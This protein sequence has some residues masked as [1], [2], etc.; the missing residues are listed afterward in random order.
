MSLSK[1]REITNALEELQKK[2]PQGEAVEQL[3]AMSFEERSWIM[4]KDRALELCKAFS[5]KHDLAELSDGKFR[6][7]A[8]DNELPRK[9]AELGRN[10]AIQ[11]ELCGST[12]SQNRE[13]FADGQHQ[14]FVFR[15]FNIDEQMALYPK[16]TE[17]L[18]EKLGLKHVPVNR[19]VRLHAIAWYHDDLLKRAGGL[20]INGKP[21]EGLVFES[22]KDGRCFEMISNNNLLRNRE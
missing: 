13:G 22:T 2:V 17:R 21:R 20:G 6:P 1:F 4:A 5:R 12:V 3:M 14:F 10:I 15:I 7:V 8:Y 18:V 16:E 11:G 9:L 19:Y